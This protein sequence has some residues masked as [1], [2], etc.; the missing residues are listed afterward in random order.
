MGNRRKARRRSRRAATKSPKRDTSGASGDSQGE[1][2][3]RPP[4]QPEARAR[5]P[6]P[7][8]SGAS[9]SSSSWAG[10][11]IRYAI[12]LGVRQSA[13]D[14]RT[15]LPGFLWNPQ[16]ITEFLQDWGLPRAAEIVCLD[17]QTALFFAEPRHSGQ[18]LSEA[19]ARRMGESISGGGEREWIFPGRRVKI[20]TDPIPIRAANRM[21]RD[22][23]GI[24][25]QP[26]VDQ[27][28]RNNDNNNAQR[29]MRRRRDASPASSVMTVESFASSET[30]S[31]RSYRPA[32]GYIRNVPKITEFGGEDA[33]RTYTQWRYDVDLLRQLNYEE[34]AL[35][36]QIVQSLK[37]QPGNKIRQMGLEA[38]IDEM[39][40]EMDTLYDSVRSYDDMI[41]ELYAVQQK[42]KET[43]GDFDTRIGH[44][45]DQIRYSHPE[46]A[47]HEN[48]DEKRR[49]HFFGGLK[50]EIKNALRYLYKQQ[51]PVA[52][53]EMV[54]AAR[55]VEGEQRNQAKTEF[56]REEYK[57]T[58]RSK[59]ATPKQVTEKP[60]E[61]TSD[62]DSD[63]EE[64]TQARA[65]QAM[66]KKQES[67]YKILFDRGV[68]KEQKGEIG[69]GCCYL[70]GSPDHR[71]PVCERLSEALNDVRGDQKAAGSPHWSRKTKPASRPKSSA[72]KAQTTKPHQ[73]MGEAS[74]H[75]P[76]N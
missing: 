52:H 41:R 17:G 51:P 15:E 4:S 29:Q 56:R 49:E 45:L 10:R 6:A 61:D 33:T 64:R 54:R 70:C 24:N 19:D 12:R 73:E 75:E 46:R 7:S 11:N 39:L 5:S 72:H 43:V 71:M 13:D 16:L 48:M 23:P 67:A 21:V 35:K 37:G 58:Y 40:A 34:A 47:A 44:A 27:E 2:V 69:K 36:F 66:M 38:S 53:T 63:S 50:D 18:G 25:R 68:K 55:E 26:Q 65:F 57:K 31:S 42:P 22:A 14:V 1:E 62:T 60:T 30:Q 9:S 74:Q 76:Q 20:Q 59:A 3:E 32:G 8:S 28:R